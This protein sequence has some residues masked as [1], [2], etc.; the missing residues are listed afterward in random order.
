L[1]PAT[2]DVLVKASPLEPEVWADPF[3]D[4]DTEL[5]DGQYEVEVEPEFY[6]TAIAY[7][8]ELL[9]GY[10]VETGATQNE[11][12]EWLVHRDIVD[13]VDEWLYESARVEKA[14]WQRSFPYIPENKEDGEC[15]RC[16]ELVLAG[17]GTLEILGARHGHSWDNRGRELDHWLISEGRA[18]VA[19][20]QRHGACW[21]FPA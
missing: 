3:E 17:D 15:F 12:G 16:G 10:L 6:P 7:G 18:R 4:F 21:H 20:L 9:Q 13:G 19:H 8:N 2:A 5:L 1:N 14:E 11:A